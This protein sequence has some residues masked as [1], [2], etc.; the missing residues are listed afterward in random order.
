MI[1]VLTQNGELLKRWPEKDAAI[2]QIRIVSDHLQS[3]LGV[4]EL[5][6]LCAFQCKVGYFDARIR[7]TLLHK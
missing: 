6:I 4:I 5:I 2:G 7:E 3:C 1:L